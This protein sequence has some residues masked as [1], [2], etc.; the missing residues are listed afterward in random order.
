MTAQKEDIALMAHL[1]RRAGFGAPRAELEERV[2][3]GYDATVEELLEPDRFD[4]PQ[5]EVDL[6]YRFE[7]QTINPGAFPMQGQANFVWQMVNTQRALQEKVALFWHHIFAT[8]NSKVDSADRILTQLEMLRQH[9]MGNYRELLVRLSTDPAM[10]FFLDNNQNHKEAPNENWGRELLE[11][12][13]MGVGNYTE[14]DVLECSRAFTGWT[15][16]PR[17]P[18]F[19]HARFP[20]DFEYQPEDHDDDEK[21]FLGHRGRFNGEDIID[22]IVRQPATARFI[23]RHLY[24]FFV[25]DEVQV[26]AWQN[27]PPRDPVAIN[28]LASAFV[29][30]NYDIRST[31]RVL[32]NSD[33]F[34]EAQFAKV[35][36]PVEV[37]VGTLNLVGGQ[38]GLPQPDILPIGAE[39]ADMGQSLLDPPSVEG[40]HTGAEWID[41]GSLVRRIN[42]AADM[43][44]NTSFPG[45]QDIVARI[46]SRGTLSPEAMVESSLDL[47]GPVLVEESTAKQLLDRATGS[48][49]LRWET[50]E[51]V[52]VSTNR[53]SEMLQLIASTREYQFG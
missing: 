43:V 11:L 21:E 40:W 36:S 37:V 50:A 6:L 28:I 31:L 1:M 25:A 47:M 45:V 20:W 17:L 44:G 16:S 39:S 30:S 10:I 41:S 35:K 29:N 5:N 7:S 18:N 23:A 22:I 32:F 19:P 14:K 8:S 38:K 51:E 4:I 15:I 3:K 42:F 2:A 48:G 13:S 24:N 12:F 52:S 34:K 26:P 33:F 9:G 46:R 53:V 27:D 49:D